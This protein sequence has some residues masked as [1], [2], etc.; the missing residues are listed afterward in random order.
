MKNDVKV[1]SLKKSLIKCA[2][3]MS[4]AFVLSAGAVFPNTLITPLTESTSITA[5]AAIPQ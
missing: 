2:A 4:L 1:K 5:N 3:V